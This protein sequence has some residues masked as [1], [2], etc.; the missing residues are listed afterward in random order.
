MN[1][2]HT[3]TCTVCGGKA[4]TAPKGYI[5][6]T[7]KQV[8]DMVHNYVQSAHAPAGIGRMMADRAGIKAA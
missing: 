3:C 1:E 6:G 8:R 4:I 7:A 5:S 2:T